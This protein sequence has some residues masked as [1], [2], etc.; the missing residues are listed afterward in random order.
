M[1][2]RARRISAAVPS[3]RAIHA[4]YREA[5]APRERSALWS[6][7]GFTVTFGAVR[8]LTYSIRAG[9]GPFHNLSLGGEHLHH[10]LWGIG[11]VSGV[12][13]LAVYGRERHRR[14]P[15]T[16]LTYGAG[17]ALII[18]EF[19]LLLDLKDV[20]WAKQGRVS[21]DLGIGVVAL[22]GTALSVRPIVN[23]LLRDRR[24]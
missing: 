15:L 23:R 20:Y 17:L 2:V 3:R 16:G 18:D 19:A 6:W 9:R 7:L 4:A 24:R 1:T 21:V 10:Y 5:L 13:A 8:A 14:H 12:G 11:M 22:G